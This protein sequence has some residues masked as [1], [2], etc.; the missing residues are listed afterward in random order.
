MSDSV[1]GSR[2]FLDRH[3]VRFTGAFLAVGG[4]TAGILY[5]ANQVVGLLVGMVLTGLLGIVLTWRTD[6]AIARI[7]QE[8]EPIESGE[9]VGLS[10]LPTVL[11]DAIE[12]TAQ[13][14]RRL[15]EVES[16]RDDL[17]SNV[18][19]HKTQS[20]RRGT[21]LDELRDA[22]Q[23][24]AA[25]RLET[26]LDEVEE[27]DDDLA[28]DF[29][30]MMDELEDTVQHLK[31][32]VGLVVSSSSR[33][34]EGT[35]E[36]EAAS[37]Q[38][39]DTIQ[40]IS[41]G[42]SKQSDQLQSV[43]EEMER[44]SSNV[45]EIAS[46]TSEV[47]TS[48][49]Q[50]A[51]TG[52]EGRDAAQAAI[53]GMNE[54]EAGAT[55]ATEAIE[56]LREEMQAIDELVE[57]IGDVAQ[58]TNMLA[59]N[60]NIEASRSSSGEQDNGEGFGVV[61]QEVKE[62]ADESQEAAN[63]IEERIQTIQAETETATE[64]VQDVGSKVS[65]HAES[66][67]LALQALDEIASYAEETH[68][69]LQNIDSAAEQ[70]AES[71]QEVVS[72]VEETA[73]ISDDTSELTEEAAAATEEQTSTLSEVSRSAN[74]LT[75][76]ASR[77]KETLDMFDTTIDPDSPGLASAVD[78]DLSGGSFDG[79]TTGHAGDESGPS[80]FEFE[81]TT[82][83]VSAS[84]NGPDTQTAT[85]G[86]GDVTA[87]GG[88]FDMG[89]DARSESEPS[90]D[91][92]SSTESPAESGDETTSG[93]AFA[94]GIATGEDGHGVGREAASSAADALGADHI[95]FCQVF[96]SS[97]YDYEAV[98]DGIR[99]VIGSGPVLIGCSSAGEFT[100]SEQA[101]GSVTVSLLSSDAMRF[102]TGLGTGLGDDATAAV[103]EAV[104]SLP[105][106]VDG[107][108]HRTAITLY[109]GLAGLGDEVPEAVQAALGEDVTI[110]GGAAADDFKLDATAVFG[111]GEVATDAVA[112]GLIA[113]E[114]PVSVGVDHGHSPISDPLTVTDAEGTTVHE[115]DG[116]PAFDA[117]R[118]A[119]QSYLTEIGEGEIDFDAIDDGSLE[120]LGVLTEFEFGIEDEATDEFAVRWPGRDLTT[121][122]SLTF[123]VEIPEGT[124]LRVL[125]SPPGD[126]IDAGRDA[127]RTA[128]ESAGDDVAG[129]F[130]YESVCRSV[131][132]GD[133]FDQAVAALS[134]EL[135]TA[136]VGVET[137]G[138]LSWN[139]DQQHGFQNTATVVVLLPE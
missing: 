62:L 99:S 93:T 20:R 111:G 41:T 104:A 90:D 24:C 1:R 75:R 123:P 27:L 66:I 105:E 47:A 15:S 10:Q 53:A 52:R 30:E 83:S 19:A 32:F 48:S 42:A 35:E 72:L 7:S 40:E 57:F 44:L 116:D 60:A 118:D 85:D 67:E 98:V 135:P 18:E 89:V 86:E 94:T 80:S 136:L 102:F 36:V 68:R 31:E 101:E 129:A 38:I 126:Q 97:E 73:A 124:E 112:I 95:D 70:Q 43:N 5:T 11:G 110:V 59:L 88:G 6:R 137:Y 21:Q 8:V 50:T 14:R 71:T 120:L 39:T 96:C 106:S 74:E 132:M 58:Q 26:R 134:D 133:T 91:V 139:A 79:P 114:R 76:K 55:E 9:V 138:Q 130:V 100:E 3:V 25:G 128:V 34:T 87:T 108:P 49:K 122:G 69:G 117:W 51:H 77:L 4:V 23:Q 33:V 46:L 113:S 29:N 107:Y 125:H 81:E 2:G 119:V 63:T 103:E 56:T 115:L 16:E 13:L 121:D 12:D 92:D 37:E 127:A 131:I 65:E 61:A 84:K 78:D 82:K 45:R 109:D 17:K 28:S 22:M 64:K 54:I